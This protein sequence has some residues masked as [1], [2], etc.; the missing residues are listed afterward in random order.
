MLVNRFTITFISHLLLPKNM[1]ANKPTSKNELVIHIPSVDATVLEI[2]V[3][4]MIKCPVEDLPKRYAETKNEGKRKAAYLFG[5]SQAFQD[6][7]D[8][9]K[10]KDVPHESYPAEDF[11]R[12]ATELMDPMTTRIF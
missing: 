6:F 12:V 3:S 11:D 5:T 2:I 7:S 9:L 10:S 8:Y 1:D 4:A